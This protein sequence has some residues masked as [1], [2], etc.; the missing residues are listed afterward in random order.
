MAGVHCRDVAEP[1]DV[2][3]TSVADP[4]P[5][6][7]ERASADGVWRNLRIAPDT[8]DETVRAETET[9]TLVVRDGTIAWLGAESDLPSEFS[10]V[11]RH[12]GAN[13]LVTPGLVDCHT[14]LVYGGDRADEFAQRLAGASYADIA[15]R[16]GG[17]LSTVR[18]TREASEDELFAAASARL[19]HLLD[20]GVC[21]IEIKSGYGLD[22]A[23]ERKQLRV[24]R[25][26]GEAHGVTVRTTFLGAHAVPPEYAG[27]VDAYVDL[28]CDEM[29]PALVEEG[30]V[31]A[32]DVFCETIAFSPAQTERIFEAATR[33]AVPVKLHAEQLSDSGAATLAAR[34]RALSAD[35][36]EYVSEKGI[37]AMRDA[38]TVAVL[39][40]G[41]FYMLRETRTPPIDALRRAGVPIAIATDH[42]PGTSPIL[43]L[44][45]VMHMACTLF[46]LTVPEMLA[47]VTRYA[48]GAL[49]LHE[50]HGALGVG[51]PANFVLWNVDSPADFGYWLGPTPVQTIVR[52]GRIATRA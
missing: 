22:L 14:H 51:R 30:F 4:L 39:L 47:G 15:A 41:A 45:T 42:N 10:G 2:S 38:G 37:A 9:D 33:L 19:Q 16:G 35:H 46:R 31:D 6:R 8:C 3:K 28:V 17:I 13:A 18:A 26:L 49:G 27:R 32:V 34:Y 48:A 1:G 11:L 25:R 29:L 40:P 7:E 36:L 43:S 5:A 52:Q 21:A 24:A 50:T 20:E 44:V 12:D 23:T